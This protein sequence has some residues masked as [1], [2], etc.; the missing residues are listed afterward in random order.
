[1]VKIE[2]ECAGVP[3]VSHK[4]S[5]PALFR[6]RETGMVVLFHTERV[7]TVVKTGGDVKLLSL[8]DEVDWVS[9]YLDVWEPLKPGESITITLT[10]E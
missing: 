1:M 10:A 3:E 9:C 8:E 7:G 2:S 5:L 6:Y 4:P